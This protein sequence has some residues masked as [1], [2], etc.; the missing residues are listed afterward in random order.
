MSEIKARVYRPDSRFETGWITALSALHKELMAFRPHIG[1]LFAK[2]F[3]AAYRGAALGVFWNFALPLLPISA[4][5]LLAGLRVFPAREGIPA[6]IYIS[7]GAT[8][9]FLMI[10][11]IRQPI[12][13]VKSRTNEVM[14]T[15][16]P[17]SASIAS[18]FAMLLFETGV[19]IGLVVVLIVAMRVWPALTAPLIIPVVLI[20]A[21]FSLSLG[22]F[23]SILNAVSP[24]IERVVTIFLQYGIFLSGVIFPVSSL[25]PLDFLEVANPFAVFITAAR[26]A[27]FGGGFSHPA[28]LA[29]W[30]AAAL[31]FAVI[32]ARFFYVM[33]YRIR[34]LA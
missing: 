32:S 25:G 20:A 4:Y 14:K 7:V 29:G 9:W 30:S 3:R 16:L 2:D 27:A 8:M 12:T 5:V 22:V 21:I 31:V 28:A 34:G 13:I 6:A 24:D 15:A 18:S 19:R 17:L 11:L 33:E 26:D 10:G 1:T 23:L